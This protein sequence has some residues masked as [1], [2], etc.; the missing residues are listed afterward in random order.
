MGKYCLL[1][2]AVDVES[3]FKGTSLIHQPHLLLSHMDN[4]GMN[5]ELKSAFFSTNGFQLHLQYEPR[6][7]E[8]GR[9]CLRRS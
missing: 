6:A 1:L 9:V 7:S 2:F 8:F 5:S 4:L 3:G